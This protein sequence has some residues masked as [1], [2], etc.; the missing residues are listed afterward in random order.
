[1]RLRTS[2]TE[3]EREESYSMTFAHGHITSIAYVNKLELMEEAGRIEWVN[4]VYPIQLKA[5]MFTA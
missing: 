2:G 5:S 1:M 4:N 3:T